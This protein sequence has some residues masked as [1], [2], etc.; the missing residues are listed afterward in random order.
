MGGGGGTGGSGTGDAGGDADDAGG[1]DPGLTACDGGC[2]D[3]Q[4]DPAHCGGCGLACV[5]PVSGSATGS[6]KCSGGSCDVTCDTTAPLDCAVTGG[7]ACVNPQTDPQYCNTC[8]THCPGGQTCKGGA[9]VAACGPGLTS[10]NGACVNLKSDPN[11]CNA[12]GTICSPLQMACSAG[13]CAVFTCGAGLTSCAVGSL[14]ACANLM[15]D[16]THCGT[17]ATACAANQV[18]VAGVCKPYI[19]ASAGWECG[20]GNALPVFCPST[21][22]CVGTGVACP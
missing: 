7:H 10:C 20:N 13:A 3:E 21:G 22:I 11:H 19:F 6:P 14:T 4:T 8:S 2:I 9:C 16:P 1:C 17:C 18:C 15:T 5:A 12:C